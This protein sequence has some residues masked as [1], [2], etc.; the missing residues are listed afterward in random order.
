MRIWAIGDLHLSFGVEDKSMD[1]FGPNWQD[2]AT[3]IAS[4]WRELIQPEDL[5]LSPGDISWALRLEDALADLLWI[6]ALPG[7]HFDLR[8]NLR[9]DQ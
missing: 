3:R 7:T 1:V 9:E 2:H 4:H 8:K 5:V 6:D